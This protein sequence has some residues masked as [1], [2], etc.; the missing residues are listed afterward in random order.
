MNKKASIYLTIIAVIL[1]VIA[2]AYLL[3]SSHFN[4]ID[5]LIKLHGG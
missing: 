4:L 3:G 1:V 5:Y 2:S